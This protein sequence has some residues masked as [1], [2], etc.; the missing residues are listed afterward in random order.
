MKVTD[1]DKRN[2]LIEFSMVP[3]AIIFVIVSV[4]VD[5]TC[6]NDSEHVLMLK[7]AILNIY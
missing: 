6:S 4:R 2:N 5:A 3:R 7:V 1:R